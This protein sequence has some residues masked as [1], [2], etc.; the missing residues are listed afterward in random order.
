MKVPKAVFSY[1]TLEEAVA[2]T[3]EVARQLSGRWIPVEGFVNMLGK[4][5]GKGPHKDPCGWLLSA[6][7]SRKDSLA[8]FLPDQRIK[9]DDP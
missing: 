7:W 8:A 9:Q 1:G 6:P 3:W 5:N 4:Q 2:K